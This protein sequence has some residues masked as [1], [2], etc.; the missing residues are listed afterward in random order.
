MKKT[1]A[2][3]LIGNEILSGRTKDANLSYLGEKLNEQGV[4]VCEA[5][6][7][8]D[9]E[10]EI[11]S[12][13][14]ALRVKYDYVF[15]T[16]GIGPTHDDITS[17]S[18]AKAFGR[19]FQRNEDAVLELEKY[20]KPADLNEA[21]LSM[22]DMP[23]NVHLIENPLSGAPGFQIEN[24]FVLAGV[25]KICQAMF[26]GIKERLD[27]GTPMLSKT[28]WCNLTEGQIA[29]QL[30]LI[31]SHYEMLEIGSYPS[32]KKGDFS[33]SIVV[34]GYEEDKIKDASKK[35]SLLVEELGGVYR[36]E[37]HEC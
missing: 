6:V 30:L 20:Y 3:L 5:R 35:V 16:G 26:D 2:I 9:I 17:K 12:A 24:V 1:A 10:D 29:D 19:I 34:R 4:R 13:V 36:E 18:V 15:T 22:A 14:N 25:P 32:F 31:Q 21:R 28:V 23:E 33:V 27:G 37:D 11:A 7:S 8:L